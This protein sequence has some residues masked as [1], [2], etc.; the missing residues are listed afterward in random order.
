[1]LHPFDGERVDE[2]RA[3]IGPAGDGLVT[4]VNPSA[5]AKSTISLHR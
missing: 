1:M 5:P 4:E 3:H 2:S